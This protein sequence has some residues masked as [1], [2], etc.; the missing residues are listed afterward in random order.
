MERR[1]ESQLQDRILEIYKLTHL[2][3]ANVDSEERKEGGEGGDWEER[4]KEGCT[5][6]KIEGIID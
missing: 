2:G 3:Y 6:G 1:K 5:L 4:E